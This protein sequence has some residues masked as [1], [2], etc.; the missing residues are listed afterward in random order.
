DGPIQNARE[1]NPVA[2]AH[3]RLP[4]IKDVISKS[5]SWSNVGLIG[6]KNACLRNAR[7]VGVTR[8]RWI[9]ERRKRFRQLLVLI[10]KANRSGQLLANFPVVLREEAEISSLK[11]NSRNTEALRVGA[12]VLRL[13][14]RRRTLRESEVCKIRRQRAVAVHAKPGE[15]IVDPV[16]GMNIVAAEFEVVA[17]TNPVHRICN[18]PAAL[19]RKRSAIQE[20][21]RTKRKRIRNT[22]TRRSAQ[23]V[24]ISAAGGAHQI[25]LLIRSRRLAVL[26]LEVASVLI[27]NL[28]GDRIR[29]HRV[30]LRDPER[31]IDIIVAEAAD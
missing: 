21:R 29:N 31:D 12:P 16:V 24:R 19:I 18:L 10:A 9:A 27:P 2:A 3:N 11:L 5:H 23:R 26:K 4:C 6:W 13:R 28:V 20:V 1:E 7:K 14:S 15:E 8:D 30:Q 25:G 22:D 17:S